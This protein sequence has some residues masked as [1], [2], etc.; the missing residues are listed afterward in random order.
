MPLHLIL[1]YLHTARATNYVVKDEILNKTLGEVGT[2]K[3]VYL[4]T[5]YEIKW[6]HSKA[7]KTWQM[8]RN[9]KMGSVIEA[10]QEKRYK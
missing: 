3:T 2:G 4:P 1:Q 10:L 7:Y 9:H 5:Q 6:W 8:I